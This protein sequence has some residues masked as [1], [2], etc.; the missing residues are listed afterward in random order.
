MQVRQGGGVGPSCKGGASFLGAGA[1]HEFVTNTRMGRKGG[2]GLS[3]CVFVIG[4]VDGFCPAPKLKY[5][6]SPYCVLMSF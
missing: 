1:V 2:G 6:Q 3:I 4:F 5:A